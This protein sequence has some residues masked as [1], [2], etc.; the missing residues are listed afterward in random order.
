[1]Q[2]S[3]A[4]H[5]NT[6]ASIRNLETQLG[7]LAK[8]IAGQQGSQ[9]LTNTQI[10]PKEHCNSITTRSGKVVEEEIG[11]N[12]VGREKK[13][14]EE[15]IESMGEK[16]KNREKSESGDENR[17]KNKKS[18]NKM[19]SFPLKNVAPLKDISYQHASSRKSKERQFITFMHILKQL[20]INMPL[21]E[22][23]EQMPTYARFM[24]ELL[25]KK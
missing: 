24:K 10:D 9:F 14:E 2:A 8:Q 7:Q 23:L 13:V 21:T 17:E 15:K 25:T 6:E 18:E 16:E 20:Q 12:L 1:M 19:R 3:M 22:A 11:D 5:K 4:N